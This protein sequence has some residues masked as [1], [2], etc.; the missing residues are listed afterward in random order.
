MTRKTE[1]N[2]KDARKIK[3][4]E[5]RPARN[6]PSHTG[7]ADRVN[8][9]KYLSNF[10]ARNAAE[11]P[12][13]IDLFNNRDQIFGHDSDRQTGNLTAFK[14][15]LKTTISDIAL[16][17]SNYG[18]C[19]IQAWCKTT[20]QYYLAS[21]D[22]GKIE[23]VSGN[24]ETAAGKT[25]RYSVTEP[26]KEIGLPFETGRMT[27]WRLLFLRDIA[28]KLRLPN[29]FDATEG[30]NALTRQFGAR[31]GSNPVPTNPFI[32]EDEV[33]KRVPC[34]FLQVKRDG[35]SIARDGEE[36]TK[37]VND[38]YRQANQAYMSGMKFEF[39]YA[40]NK[41]ACSKVVCDII[42]SVLAIKNGA[43]YLMCV[44][45]NK[46]NPLK[47]ESNNKGLPGASGY[48]IR[49][50]K[51]DRMSRPV[52]SAVKST[53]TVTELADLAKMVSTN[54]G[55]Y[56]CPPDERFD[57]VVKV[58]PDYIHYFEESM[59]FNQANRMNEPSLADFNQPNGAI[60]YKIKGTNRQHLANEVAKS[61][62]N[63]VVIYPPQAIEFIR[64]ELLNAVACQTQLEPMRLA[65]LT[66][67]SNYTRE[68]QAENL[69]ATGP[70]L[71]SLP[72]P[73][74]S[75]PPETPEQ[76]GADQFRDDPSA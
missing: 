58:G 49:S 65:T 56:Y 75:A 10:A 17:Q 37:T 70:A 46:G 51:F 76:D 9:L 36:L 24:K 2:K 57:A 64:A 52:V 31:K 41:G 43:M 22:T 16:H 7:G 14:T 18:F 25:L 66:H 13:G 35:Y 69:V 55:I 60:C 1:N 27:L 53:L 40:N 39:D 38:S 34:R 19:N 12:K 21:E 8:L 5:S 28:S 45:A 48:A 15:W 71:Q 29:I 73:L 54:D 26:F 68:I 6:P 32:L 30:L 4:A 72:S 67:D 47:M 42:C 11:W 63:L 62:G 61:R 74:L 23:A 50:Y 44:P 33:T 59:P 3:R 20:N